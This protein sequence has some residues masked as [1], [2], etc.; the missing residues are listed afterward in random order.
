MNS[1]SLQHIIQELVEERTH[2]TTGGAKAIPTGKEEIYL[3]AWQ[4]V[5]QWLESRLRQRKGAELGLLGKFTWEFKREKGDLSFRPIFIV[6]SSFCKEHHI[7][8]QRLHYNQVL[9]P[10]EEI[11]Y[12]KLA[13][14]FSKI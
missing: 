9:A 2:S 6:G 8:V 7:R 13:I 14:R 5:N 11:N 3:S 10:C 1:Y 4:S 12:S